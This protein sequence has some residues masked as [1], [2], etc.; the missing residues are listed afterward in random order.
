MQMQLNQS[1]PGDGFM[2]ADR[3]PQDHFSTASFDLTRGDRTL[4]AQSTVRLSAG[5]DCC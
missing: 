1:I 4:Q 2:K 5:P 3:T